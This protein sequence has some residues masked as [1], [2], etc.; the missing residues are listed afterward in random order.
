MDNILNI[1]AGNLKLKNR[2]FIFELDS[3][4]TITEDSGTHLLLITGDNGSGKTTFLEQ[5]IIPQLKQNKIFFS[6]KGQDNH[7]QNIIDR[8]LEAIFS[9]SHSGKELISQILF[10]TPV[11]PVIKKIQLP[12]VDVIL[13][14]ETDKLLSDEDL[15]A[16][17]NNPAYKLLILVSHN[18]D[19]PLLQNWLSQYRQKYHLIIEGQSNIRSARLAKC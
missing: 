18:S 11:P 17:F 19:N 7:I 15:L 8:S 2:P 9:I 14:D 10:N 12:A 1:P 16:I 4:I 5:I 13:M 6:F 3:P